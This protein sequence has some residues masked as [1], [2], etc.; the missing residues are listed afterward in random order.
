MVRSNLT[1]KSGFLRGS[2]KS[3]G[4]VCGRSPIWLKLAVVS[5]LDLKSLVEAIILIFGGIKVDLGGIF[6]QNL[7]KSQNCFLAVAFLPLSVGK[8]C[9]ISSNKIWNQAT[10]TTKHSSVAPRMSILQ[11]PQVLS[12]FWP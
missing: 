4:S 1:I 6:A 10:R 11:L 9:Y 7:E 5:R 8:S 12:H 2:P 3:G